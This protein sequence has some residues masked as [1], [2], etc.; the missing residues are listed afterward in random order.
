MAIK[1]GSGEILDGDN[2]GN[3]LSSF[4]IDEISH[5]LPSSR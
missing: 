1:P 4:Q 3:P 5:R 2:A